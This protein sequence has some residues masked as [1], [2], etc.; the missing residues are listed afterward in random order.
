MILDCLFQH[1]PLGLGTAQVIKKKDIELPAGIAEAAAAATRAIT[2]GSLLFS[3]QSLWPVEPV[4]M[5]SLSG[6]MFGLMLRILPAYVRQ[7]FSDL[8][9]R[10][11]LFGIESFTRAWCSPPLIANELSLVCIACERLVNSVLLRTCGYLDKKIIF[12][13]C[14]SRG[15]TCS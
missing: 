7:W 10:S 14:F 8:R 9:D 5:A 2:T 11:T 13:C 15:G 3:V 12:L 1:I 4:K 6:A